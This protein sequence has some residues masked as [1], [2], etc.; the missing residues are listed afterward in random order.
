MYSMG[1][2][3]SSEIGIVDAA[4]KA[5]ATAGGAGNATLVHGTAI[6]V[7][8][9]ASPAGG[10]AGEGNARYNSVCFAIEATATLADT[11]SLGVTASIE[12][13]AASNFGTAVTL[14]ATTT[15]LTL[16]SV[17][18]TTEKGVGKIGCSLDGALQYVR[19][20]FTPTLT[21]S[22]TD[23]SDIQALAIFGGSSEYP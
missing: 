16:T 19:V 20:S 13:S 4:P 7:T 14:V 11:K 6:D 18:G 21:A 8:A 17:G 23:V 12:T 2:D 1:K 3:I 22:G 9:L 10:G 15:V 5:T